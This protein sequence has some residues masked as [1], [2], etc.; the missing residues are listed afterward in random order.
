M[1]RNVDIIMKSYYD[2]TMISIFFQKGN[3]T[4]T[5]PLLYIHRAWVWRC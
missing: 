5:V 1:L 4:S 2:I 3:Q